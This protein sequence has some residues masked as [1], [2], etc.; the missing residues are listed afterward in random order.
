VANAK[1]KMKKQLI[2]FVLSGMFTLVSCGPNDKEKTAKENNMDSTS[3]MQD[4]ESIS[5][6]SFS[7]ETF[8][9]PFKFVV[10]S[11]E[12]DVSAL[13]K[14]GEDKLTTINKVNEFDYPVGFTA[15]FDNKDAFKENLAAAPGEILKLVSVDSINKSVFFQPIKSAQMK[16]LRL[17]ARVPERSN[18]TSVSY[19]IK[20][21][22]MIAFVLGNGQME[23]D[24]AYNF[25]FKE[26]LYCDIADSC[27]NDNVIS[28]VW[29]KAATDL[30]KSK[31]YIVKQAYVVSY[32][33][34][35]YKKKTINAAG[36][37]PDQGGAIKIGADVYV[38]S[39]NKDVIYKAKIVALPLKNFVTDTPKPTQVP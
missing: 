12:E 8:S 15:Y 24:Q 22:S 19:N 18:L 36:S 27:F 30:E 13:N 14:L 1:I 31:L 23:T 6:E 3:T 10:P 34:S 37:I 21:K 16:G 26:D 32:I 35:K 2:L 33:T 29:N 4:S 9:A 25:T 17:I 5:N 39:N 38:G 11:S 7:A 28:E 20:S